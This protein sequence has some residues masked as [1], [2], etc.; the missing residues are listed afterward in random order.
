MDVEGLEPG[1]D[2]VSAIE[3]AVNVCDVMI[4][5]IGPEWLMA[6][7]ENQNRRLDNP[8][9][10]I[11]LEILSAFKNDMR[12]I[13]VLTEGALSP[14][15]SLLPDDIKKLARL[16][17]LEI[18]H[19]R[20]SA[21]S[22]KLAETIMKFFRRKGIEP[23]NDAQKRI[24]PWLVFGPLGL[25]IFSVFCIILF[26][27]IGFPPQL[28]LQAVNANS[29]VADE[30]TEVPT[31][32]VFTPTETKVILTNTIISSEDTSTPVPV[33]IITNTNQPTETIIPSEEPTS[34]PLQI[35]CYPEYSSR[36][37]IGDRA[38]VI[39]FQVAGRS[40]PGYAYE[41]EHLL[42]KGRVVNVEEGPE[43]NDDGWWWRIHYSGFLSDGEYHSYFTWVLEG[44][45]ENYY[46]K[47]LD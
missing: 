3:R 8:D 14:D 40:G 17:A 20:F 36:L 34:E 24:N 41:K 42:A 21:D 44:D 18:R 10:F 27:I 26:V 31:D 47:P 5:I 7:D 11:R 46:L 12:V 37:E 16:Q 32:T 43:C 2:F 33:Q 30:T 1:M 28:N 22:E 29:Q 13:P 39:V 38:E 25:V 9:D 4:V 19:D 6:K 23:R 45:E 35:N 15:E